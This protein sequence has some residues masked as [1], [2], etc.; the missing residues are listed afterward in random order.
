MRINHGN[1][2]RE[3]ILDDHTSREATACA[4]GSDQRELGIRCSWRG[5][6]HEHAFHRFP[7]V[8]IFRKAVDQIVAS[9]DGRMDCG[10]VA[11]VELSG[12]RL[13]RSFCQLQRE[14]HGDCPWMSIFCFAASPDQLGDR[15]PEF[16]GNSGFYGSDRAIHLFSYSRASV[17]RQEHRS[18]WFRRSI[19][20]SRLPDR[21]QSQRHAMNRISYTRLCCARAS[22]A[23]SPGSNE[24]WQWQKRAC[25]SQSGLVNFVGHHL[26]CEPFINIPLLAF[27]V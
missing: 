13:E 5:R 25:I 1:W 19:S 3:G 10:M 7:P 21:P 11:A 6:G 22:G 23:I 12:D 26:E 18:S 2:S 17:A 24:G 15:Y 9:A 4:R 14:L 8:A 27:T 20:A 16:L